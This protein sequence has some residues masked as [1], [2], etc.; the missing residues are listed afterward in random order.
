MYK[1]TLLVPVPV[2]KV[3]TDGADRYGTGVINACIFVLTPNFT[4][5]TETPVLR[6]RTVDILCNFCYRYFFRSL[7][8]FLLF[9]FLEFFVD[10][11]CPGKEKKRDT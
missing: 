8:L 4:V 9:S 10:G 6:Y 2:N 11:F 7:L 5:H 3:P 1:D